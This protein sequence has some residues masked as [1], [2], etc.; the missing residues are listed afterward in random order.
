[1]K[2]VFDFLIMVLLARQVLRKTAHPEITLENVL[3]CTSGGVPG[4]WR[5]KLF[6]FQSL[7][8]KVGN[9]RRFGVR[10]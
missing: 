10:R 8:P 7:L 9:K 6:I 1:M 3:K 2:S 5:L 4:D